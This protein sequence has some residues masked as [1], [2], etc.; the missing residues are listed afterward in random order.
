M[1]ILFHKG[2]QMKDYFESQKR[3]T[4]INVTTQLIPEFKKKINKVQI[5]VNN[6]I[7]DSFSGFKT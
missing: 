2:V 3:V 5:F 4:L 1:S 7:I 6:F